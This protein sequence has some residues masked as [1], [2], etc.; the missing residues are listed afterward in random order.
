VPEQQRLRPDGQDT[1]RGPRT[2]PTQQRQDESIAGL[3]RNS[4][5]LAPED[6]NLVTQRHQLNV[7]GPIVSAADEGEIGE[8]GE[9][10][11]EDR[12]QQRRLPD[13]RCDTLADP[14][15]HC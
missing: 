1:P 2:A 5:N 11:I 6:A 13:R 4:S 15:V 10:R 7:A 12:Q 8:Q 14:S 3:P 9:E